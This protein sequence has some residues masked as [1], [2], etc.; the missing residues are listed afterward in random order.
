MPTLQSQQEGSLASWTIYAS[1][2]SRV[3]VGLV[4]QEELDHLHIAPARR[5]VERRDP[6]RPLVDVSSFAQQHL[7]AFRLTV[8][9][10]QM[11]EPVGTLVC[12]LREFLR[13]KALTQGASV[14]QC[15]EGKEIGGKIGRAS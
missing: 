1:R 8:Q 2:G 15:H 7:D 9:R 10:C 11:Q 6:V 5:P 3:D 14:A 12:R 4:F 13:F